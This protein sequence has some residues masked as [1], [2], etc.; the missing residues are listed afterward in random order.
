[1]MQQNECY[2]SVTL[3]LSTVII[4]CISF[5]AVE[6]KARVLNPPTHWL[7]RQDKDYAFLQVWDQEVHMMIVSRASGL[8]NYDIARERAIIGKMRDITCVSQNMVSQSLWDEFWQSC[9]NKNLICYLRGRW[10]IFLRRSSTF[11]L[12]GASFSCPGW[13]L[14]WLQYSEFVIASLQIGQFA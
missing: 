2:D 13:D 1:M 14:I 3:Y 9:C 11:F 12:K 7:F 6:N 10:R 4:W 5:R 8:L